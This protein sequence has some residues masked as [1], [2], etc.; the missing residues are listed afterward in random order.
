VSAS[1]DPKKTRQGRLA[2]ALR[3]NLVKRKMQAKLEKA[4]QIGLEDSLIVLLPTPSVV[5]KD[6]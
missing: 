1:F 4:G 2:Q 5:K 3:E 6:T